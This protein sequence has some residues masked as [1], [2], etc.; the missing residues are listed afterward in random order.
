MHGHIS[1]LANTALATIFKSNDEIY[2]YCQTSNCELVEIAGKIAV[3][4][5]GCLPTYVPTGQRT[6]IDLTKEKKETAAKRFTPLAAVPFIWINPSNFNDRRPRRY[7]FY[8]DCDNYLR[9]VY[10]ESGQWY[11]GVLHSSLELKCAPYSKLAAV[12]ITNAAGVDFIFLYYQDINDS[13]NIQIAGLSHEGWNC[14]KPPLCDPPLWGTAITAVPA[15][16]GIELASDTHDPVVFFQQRS[17]ELSSSQDDGTDDYTSYAIPDKTM[18]LSGHAY[19]AAVND[20]TDCWCFYTS[21]QN[22]IHR[23]RIDANGRLIGP[24]C[25]GLDRTPIPASSLAAVI[26]ADC[27]EKIV[28]FYLLH[29]TESIRGYGHHGH[30]QTHDKTHGKTNVYAST[31]T[32][33]SPDRW[34]A[35]SGRLLVDC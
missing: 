32:R 16:P 25:V 30:G 11:C 10:E 21:D 35:S 7:L 15:E 6:S 33:I 4:E 12:K 5:D 29:D 13:G 14:G 3:L 28:L 2:T 24:I 17:L 27:P 22:D 9:D 18:A 19:I 31:L 1:F 8:V 20:N 26:T 34:S 23:I